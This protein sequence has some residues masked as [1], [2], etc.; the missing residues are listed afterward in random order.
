MAVLLADRQL[1]VRT[2]GLPILDAYGD[3]ATGPPGDLGF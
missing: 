1:G 2:R 3:E